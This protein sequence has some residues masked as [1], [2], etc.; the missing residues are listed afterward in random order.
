MKKI[1][2]VTEY[3]VWVGENEHVEKEF[4]SS[5]REYDE[6]DN[7]NRNFVYREDGMLESGTDLRY[8]ERH[9]V[10]EEINYM[11][12]NEIAEHLYFR[13][14]D[15][16]KIKEIETVYADG[17][18]SVKKGVFD[19]N[20]LTITS[21]DEDEAYEGEEIKKFDNNENVLEEILLDEDKNVTERRTYDYDEDGNL[22]S[23][24]EFGENGE[25]IIRRGIEYDEKGNPIKQSSYN[26]K[27]Q[28]TSVIL[29]KY[30]N[31]NKMI[32]QQH[33]NRYLLKVE[34]DENGRR[35]RDETTNLG[36]DMVEAL[37]I[38]KYDE[39][40]LLVEE[41]SH[42]LHRQPRQDQKILGNMDSNYVRTRYAYEFY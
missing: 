26:Q 14:D 12:E 13:Y 10:V 42:E 30:N 25:F 7:I 5:N 35:V 34:Y 29:S 23:A 39:D 32:S 4:K 31:E 2:T 19:K 33:D 36:S 16:G 15:N 24:T 6:H 11:D 27:G 40:G 21:Y 18:K 8:D 41:I 22:T 3:T 37:R 20:T 28:L 17:S 9:N 1:K 38:Y